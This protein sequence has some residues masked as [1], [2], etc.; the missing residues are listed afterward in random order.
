MPNVSP[1]NHARLYLNWL[2]KQR[3][4]VDQNTNVRFI[5]SNNMTIPENFVKINP[6]YSEITGLI[7]ISKKERRNISRT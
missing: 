7:K 1:H 5:I 3:P 4:L 6:V 2:P